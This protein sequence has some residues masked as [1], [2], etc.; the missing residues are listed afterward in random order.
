MRSADS[1]AR[2]QARSLARVAGRW[3]AD[4]AVRGWSTRARP[5]AP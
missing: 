1:G 2:P 3:G 4:G 5:R